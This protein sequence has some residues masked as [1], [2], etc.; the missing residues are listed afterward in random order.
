VI[1]LK[2]ILKEIGETTEPYPFELTL[3]RKR[4]S[5]ATLEYQFVNNNYDTIQVN[6][7]VDMNSPYYHGPEFTVTFH[8]LGS[9][10]NGEEENAKYKTMTGSGDALKVISTVV[11]CIKEAS[12]ELLGSI[13]EVYAIHFSGDDKRFKTYLKYAQKQLPA[14]WKIETRDEE[15][16]DLI[17]VNKTKPFVVNP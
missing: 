3:N 9:E 6:I 12:K 11:A 15:S 8:D 13:D 17:N 2:D 1:K 4:G 10:D 14:G 7:M 5:M 16:I